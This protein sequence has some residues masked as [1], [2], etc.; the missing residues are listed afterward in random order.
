MS[1]EVE[2]QVEVTRTNLPQKREQALPPMLAIEQE[3][4]IY[5]RMI[6]EKRKGRGLHHP[7]NPGLWISTP[8]DIGQR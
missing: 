7:C 2:D 4:F 6:F 1:L 5:G 8:N 3:D